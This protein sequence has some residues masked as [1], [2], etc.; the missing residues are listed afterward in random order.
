M[1]SKHNCVVLNQNGVVQQINHYY[2]YGS[3]MGEGYSASSQPYRYGGKELVT[4]ENLNLSDFGARW[5]DS[6]SGT[7][8]TM[9]PLCEKYTQYSPYLYCAGNPIKYIDP[10]GKFKI[11]VQD[12]KISPA[13]NL[14]LKRGIS[15]VLE[16][17]K[18]VKALMKNG[19]FTREQ[20]NED[21][22]YGKGPII[23]LDPYIDY[24]GL[25]VPKEGSDEL[26]IK[27]D[28]VLDL[29]NA[30]G[31]KKDALL[32]LIAVIILHEYVHYGDNQDGVQQEVEEGVQFEMDAYG[33]EVTEYNM[34]I[35]IQEWIN[36][37][38]INE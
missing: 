7:F 18:I 33:V 19:E 10:S 26:K 2:P 21:F 17:P 1:P 5:L 23:Q 16:N 37:Q 20:L 35:I 22:M 28:V 3:M 9:D 30:D 27:M 36:R 15:K 14:Y 13:L 25:F 29:E 6:P 34:E 31:I 38:N 24:Y 32:F 11:S 12:A 8:T 4:L